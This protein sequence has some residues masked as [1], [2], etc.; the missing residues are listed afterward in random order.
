M[1]IKAVIFDMDGVLIDA[2]EWHFEALNR[3]L[4]IFGFEIT[5]Q[6]HIALFDGLPTKDKLTLLSEEQGLPVSLHNFIN[7]LKQSFT[8]E[9]IFQKCRPTFNHEYA[10]AKLVQSGY[11][12]AVASNSIRSTVQLM[13]EKANLSGYL[14]FILSNEDVSKAKPD[15][16]IYLVAMERLNLRPSECLILEDNPHGLHAARMSGAHVL[17]VDDPSM[18]TW[19]LI[20][21]EISRIDN[22]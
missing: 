8:V 10:L 11:S 9:L 20:S 19:D 21:A 14:E 2:R 15:P 16:E 5:R 7:E 1:T 18:V 22:D 17:K 13:M 6:D 4:R 3:A 12:I